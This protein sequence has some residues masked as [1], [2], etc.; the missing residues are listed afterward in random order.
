V[1]QEKQL[2]P[3]FDTPFCRLAGVRLPIVQAPIGGM[4]V[5]E[6]AAVSE[7]GGLGPPRR[8]R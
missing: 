8:G 6:L 2:G 3:T 4:A 1:T 7:A 5:A